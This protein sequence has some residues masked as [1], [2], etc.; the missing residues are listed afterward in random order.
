MPLSIRAAAPADAGLLAR[1]NAAVQD[2]HRERR[3][4]WFSSTD[5]TEVAAWFGVQLTEPGA[6]GWIA[7]VDDVPAGYVLALPRTRDANPFGPAQRW[8]E[9]DQ[10]AVLPAYRRHGVGRAL[11][12]RVVEHAGEVGLTTIE[13]SSWAFNTEAHRVFAAAGFAVRVMRFERR[14]PGER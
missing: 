5:P 3:P 9:L 12:G 14:M 4:D 10:I 7:E 11:V 13:L 6:C 2:L 8:L 1:L